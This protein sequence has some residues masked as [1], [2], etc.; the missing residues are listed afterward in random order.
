VVATQA[1]ETVERGDLVRAERARILST[2]LAGLDSLVDAAVQAIRAEIPAYAARDGIFR[3]VREQVAA[4][5]RTKLTA[6]LEERT[7]TLEEVA[8]IRGAATRRARAGLALEDYIAAYR[9]GEK[10]L[11]DAV[12][13]VAGRS[14][15]GHEAALTLAAPLMRYV[16]FV[17]T[18]AAR[19]YVEFQQFAVADANRERR[20]LLE[21]LLSG[22]W[23]PPA[24]LREAAERYGVGP[25]TPL[26][27]IVAVATSGEPDAPHTVSGVLARA[28]GW[29]AQPLVVVRRDE[30]VALAALSSHAD[31]RALSARVA[32]AHERLNA[33]GITFAVAVS[34]V[35]NGP[36][37]L[38][39]VYAEARQGVARI[40]E[41]GGVV[42][43]PSLSAFEY[44]TSRTD[45]TVGRLV[46]P[47]VRQVLAEDR[48]RG[49]VLATTVRAFAEADLSLRVT[50]ERLH[51]HPN[52]AQYRLRRLE[53]RTGRNPR[54]FRD[55]IELLVAIALDEQAA[56]V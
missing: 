29:K 37:E 50:A 32:A 40:A 49:S 44:L 52:T 22:E 25:E 12:V 19:A 45:D 24:E 20:D 5:Y 35:A 27:A 38:P 15:Q 53:E 47:R 39:R 16:D 30:I 11:W 1:V 18:H 3:D 34:T 13:S 2:L 8:F 4:H 21:Q 28:A 23:P 31:A 55:L 7:V 36:G 26:V 56:S 48:A 6:F 46:D 41:T 9:V 17:T 14:P 10:V 43:L 42:A 54:R 51:I 33:E